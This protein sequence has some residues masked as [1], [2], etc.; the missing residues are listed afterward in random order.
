MKNLR[1]CPFCGGTVGVED[2]WDGDEYRVHL[3]CRNC[4]AEMIVYGPSRKTAKRV[5]ADS[6]NRRSER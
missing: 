6:W 5:V 2:G 3:Y 4:P 1:S